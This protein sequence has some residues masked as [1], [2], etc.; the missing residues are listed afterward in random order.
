MTTYDSIEDP[1][2]VDFLETDQLVIGT[3]QPVALANLS[4][5]ARAA[6]WALRIFTLLVAGAV[7]F[8][9]VVALV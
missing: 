4:S 2:L 1:L 9:F 5:T 6:L 8:A 7:V 3:S